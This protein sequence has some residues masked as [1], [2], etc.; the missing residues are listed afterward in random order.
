MTVSRIKQSYIANE[1]MNQSKELQKDG[2]TAKALWYRAIGNMESV[3]VLGRVLESIDKKCDPTMSAKERAYKISQSTP[4][5]ARVKQVEEIIAP[6]IERQ[7]NQTKTPTSSTPQEKSKPTQPP[8]DGFELTAE[9]KNNFNAS[10]TFALLSPFRILMGPIMGLQMVQALAKAMG[11][12]NPLPPIAKTILSHFNPSYLVYPTLAG[13]IFTGVTAPNLLNPAGFAKTL[14][15]IS[16]PGRT[17]NRLSATKRQLIR[18]W[19]GIGAC[20]NNLGKASI[21]T[22]AK[23]FAVHSI[24]AIGT[25]AS[26]YA[27]ANVAFQNMWYLSTALANQ[28]AWPGTEDLTNQMNEACPLA[29]NFSPWNL[30]GFSKGSPWSTLFSWKNSPLWNFVPVVGVEFWMKPISFL[31]LYIPYPKSGLD[32]TPILT[33]GGNPSKFP[34]IADAASQSV[35]SLISYFEK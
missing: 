14:W 19:K 4:S 21:G 17:I 2:R 5:Q 33:C 27:L 31:P 11:E 8:L 16:A 29:K 25:V 1:R 20:Y 10:I 26:H 28:M 32:M 9:D 18:S 30:A 3:P 6:I 7:K 23:N 24:N 15:Q 13:S 34:S 22:I 35:D 12:D